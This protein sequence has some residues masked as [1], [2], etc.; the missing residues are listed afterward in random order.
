M[1]Y[2]KAADRY[3]GMDSYTLRM[4]RREVVGNKARPEELIMAKFR[5]EPFSI[6]L[7]W[8]GEEGKGREVAYVK[9]QYEDMVHTLMAPGDLFLFAGKHFKVAPDSPLVKSNCRYPITEA[10]L[11]P[12]IARFGRLA[13]AV[14]KGESQEGSAKYLGRV[15]R[16]EFDEP[17]EEV[18]QTLPA[19]YEG[20]FPA[21]GE[22]RW[23]FDTTS[24]LP[25]LIITTD[26]K[27]RE[28][29]YYCHDR[30]Q[31]PVR[32]DNDDF[33]PYVLWKAAKK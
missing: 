10:G 29:E 5:R 6:Y 32:L 26:D 3:A 12:L 9:G 19:K 21:G 28:V 20:L 13:T 27:G 2:E 23:F 30:I 31:A 22:R 15:K 8:V 17:V 24:G 25:V 11:G 18:V 7:K 4:R 33:N 16:P 14:E 1:I